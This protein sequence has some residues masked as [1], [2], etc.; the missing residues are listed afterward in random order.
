MERRKKAPSEGHRKRVKAEEK[1][2]EV[3]TTKKGGLKMGGGKCVGAHYNDVEN[4]QH[5]SRCQRAAHVHGELFRDDKGGREVGKE[6]HKA[7]AREKVTGSMC[8]SSGT[9]SMSDGTE[10]RKSAGKGEKCKAKTVTGGRGGSP[11]GGGSPSTFVGGKK[12]KRKTGSNFLS[13]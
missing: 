9:T 4:S 7:G 5:C 13:T 12:R 6:Q 10:P 3:K 8:L 1:E 2:K 11:W